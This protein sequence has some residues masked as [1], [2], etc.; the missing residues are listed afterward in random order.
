ME[1][2]DED[3]EYDPQACENFERD[4]K[5]KFYASTRV[6]PP[7]TGL[8]V[9]DANGLSNL[10]NGSSSEE[11]E[12]DLTSASDQSGSPNSDPDQSAKLRLLRR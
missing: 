1:K 8:E 9:V 10:L 3:A 7:G 11:S 2:V 6:L 4:A 5:E 12:M